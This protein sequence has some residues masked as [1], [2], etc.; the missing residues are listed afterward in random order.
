MAKPEGSDDLQ[1]EVIYSP[2]PRQVRAWT[3]RLLEGATLRDALVASVFPDYPELRSAGLVSGV[4]G[5]KM[6]LHHKLQTADRVEV[7][8]AL[9]VDPKVARRERFKGQ[10]AK[11]AGLFAKSRVGAKAGY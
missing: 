10:G 3:V 8:R 1:I 2:G 5:R 6:G 4:W 11:T 9:R 7:Y